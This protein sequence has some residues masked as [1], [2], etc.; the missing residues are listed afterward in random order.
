M[1]KIYFEASKS[2]SEV[3]NYYKF[4]EYEFIYYFITGEIFFQFNG[5]II[6]TNWGY[7][8]I[9]SLANFLKFSLNEKLSNFKYFSPDTDDEINF[10]LVNGAFMIE[11]SFDTN[12]INVP[13]DDFYKAVDDFHDSVFD[14]LNDNYKEVFENPNF[15]DFLELSKYKR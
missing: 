3:E 14:F 10:T 13:I 7:E 4:E 1:F 2:Q 12:I 9:L 6:T 5:N 11:F 8:Q 15:S